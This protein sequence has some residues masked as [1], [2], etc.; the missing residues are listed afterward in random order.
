MGLGL[1]VCLAIVHA[2]NGTM[3]AK[4]T[5]TGAEFSFRLPLFD[6]EVPL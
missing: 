4:N 3:D 6:E 5:D 1:S 2:H